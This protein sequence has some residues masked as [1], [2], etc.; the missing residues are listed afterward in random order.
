MLNGEWSNVSRVS[1]GRHRHDRQAN[2]P[3]NCFA[4]AV[5]KASAMT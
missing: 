2:L 1:R 4:N 3:G 5:V